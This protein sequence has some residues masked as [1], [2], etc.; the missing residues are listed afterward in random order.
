VVCAAKDKQVKEHFRSLAFENYDTETHT[1]LLQVT[2]RQHYEW[3]EAD[4]VRTWFFAQLKRHF[5]DIEVLNYRVP[6]N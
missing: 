2:S 4:H 6:K 1:I 5:P 3:M